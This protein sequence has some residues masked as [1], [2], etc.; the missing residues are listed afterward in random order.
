MNV[1]HADSI[2]AGSSPTLICSIEMRSEVDVA[3]DVFTSWIGPEGTMLKQ[4]SQLPLTDITSN[5]LYSSMAMVDAARNGT[6]ICQVTVNSSSLFI[7]GVGMMNGS[8][9]ISVG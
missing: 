1:T 8:V 6:Y 4:I 5:G 7:T 2:I 3:V 9:V